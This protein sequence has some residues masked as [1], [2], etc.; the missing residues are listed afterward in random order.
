MN[1]KQ[2]ITSVFLQWQD[3]GDLSPLVDAIDENLVWIVTGSSPISGTYSSKQD[4]LDKVIAPLQSLL[5]TPITCKLLKV[6]AEGD[7]VVVHWRGNATAKSG[8]SYN[9][10]YCW[11]LEV[12]AGRIKKVTGFY[13]SRLVTEL[14]TDGMTTQPH[15]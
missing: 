15:S 4:W 3:S 13:D 1:N 5:A 11:L 9:Q 10:E 2:F 7:D 6:I 12:D 14:F 8:K